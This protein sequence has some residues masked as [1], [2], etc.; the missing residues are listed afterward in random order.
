M[1]EDE[2]YG[3]AWQRWGGLQFDV[4]ME[5]MAELTKEICKMRR[6]KDN[7]DEICEEI[8]DVSVVLEQMKAH[9]GREKCEA[10]R[11]AKLARLEKTLEVV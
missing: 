11:Q 4:L 5:E 9:F 10:F 8:A 6:G 1:N 2:L 3:K 7:R